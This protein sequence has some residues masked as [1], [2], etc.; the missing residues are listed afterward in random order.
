MRAVTLHSLRVALDFQP[1][2]ILYYP[3]IPS[4]PMVADLLGIAH[5]LIELAP[6]VAPTSAFPAP[7]T[8][9]TSLGPLN[10]DVS[11]ERLARTLVESDSYATRNDQLARELTNGEGLAVGPSQR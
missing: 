6:V 5:V 10:R 1:D 8:A 11:A 3:K 7:G 9:T 4:A 2:I